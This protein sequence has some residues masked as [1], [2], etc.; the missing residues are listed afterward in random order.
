MD[1]W[2]YDQMEIYAY[3]MNRTFQR[4]WHYHNDK[5]RWDIEGNNRREIKVRDYH[6]LMVGT[7]F[8]NNQIL[9]TKEKK[10]RKIWLNYYITFNHN[11]IF[12]WTYQTFT[13]LTFV[14]PF[15]TTSKCNMFKFLMLT[16]F[17]GI[18]LRT[19]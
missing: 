11:Q 15:L 18:T 14:Y 8:S 2:M 6:I 13:S 3:H 10:R 16:W 7:L 17:F 9:H 19:T 4:L 1:I 12:K 5:N